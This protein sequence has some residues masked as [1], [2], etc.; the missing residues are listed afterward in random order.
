QRPTVLAYKTLQR[1]EFL[2]D[3]CVVGVVANPGVLGDRVHHEQ[4]MRLLQ[5]MRDVCQRVRV[6]VLRNGVDREVIVVL[7]AAQSLKAL[8]D[9]VRWLLGQDQHVCLHRREPEEGLA[10]RN[11]DEER[12]EE[13]GFSYLGVRRE[14]V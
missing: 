9:N 1:G 11:G 3:L 8:L 2:R 13:G 4:A 14:D 5:P 7:D 10:P 6:D 12:I